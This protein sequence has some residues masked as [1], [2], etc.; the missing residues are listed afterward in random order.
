VT[1]RG[2]SKWLFLLPAVAVYTVFRVLPILASLVLSTVEWNGLGRAVFV[3]F[4]N[5]SELLRDYVFH[6]AISNNLRLM[7][8][9]VLGSVVV[10]FVLAY[11][12]D[13]IV[14]GKGAFR[15]M[16]FVPVLLSGLV[17]GLVWRWAL[18]PSYGV[19]NVV[20]RAVGLDGLI[21]NWL[22]DGRVLVRVIIVMTIWQS[23]GR[24]FVMLLA[25]LQGIPEEISEAAYIDGAKEWQ[26]LLYVTVPMLRPIMSVVVTLTLINAFRMFDAFY[27]MSDRG[28]VERAEVLS[29]YLYKSGMTYMRFGYSSAIAVVQL[30][31]VMVVSIFYFR[32]FSG[33]SRE[34]A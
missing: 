18:N 2:P 15:I 16:L 20:L 29:T 9:Y 14:Q 8:F 23:Y 28:A 31:L 19:V 32:R 12:V 24:S 13:M 30:L 6:I 26:R 34:D 7:V 5:F 33:A 17:I 27:I 22:G 4:G 1:V 10:G 3:G 11:L 21:R 25:G